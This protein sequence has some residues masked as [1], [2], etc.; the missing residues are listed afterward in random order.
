MWLQQQLD[1]NTEGSNCPCAV[2]GLPP[3]KVTDGGGVLRHPLCGRLT[4]MDDETPKVKDAELGGLWN[5]TST[6]QKRCCLRKLRTSSY[7][8][9]SRWTADTLQQCCHSGRSQAKTS[10]NSLKAWT[11]RT[12]HK[13]AMMKLW[14]TGMEIHAPVERQLFCRHCPDTWV[15]QQGARLGLQ[16]WARNCLR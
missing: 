6:S 12:Q 11:W 4:G 5:T 10:M 14:W 8:Q 3:W 7:P 13:A 1:P 16:E 9:I 2:A 15:H